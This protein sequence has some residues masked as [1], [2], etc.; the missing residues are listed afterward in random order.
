MC[1][2][3]IGSLGMSVNDYSFLKNFTASLSL[4]DYS[5][6][7]VN[8]YGKLEL[9]LPVVGNNMERN[10]FVVLFFFNRDKRKYYCMCAIAWEFHSATFLQEKL[11]IGFSVISFAAITTQST[12][13][14]K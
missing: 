11:Y 13:Q 3:Y 9:S 2:N 8:Y 1:K 4:G 5:K 10:P 12:A 7:Q 6:H 14:I